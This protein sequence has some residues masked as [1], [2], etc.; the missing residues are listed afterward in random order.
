MLHIFP[1]YRPHLAYIKK[2]THTHKKP[3]T[4]NPSECGC[5]IYIFKVVQN[6]MQISYYISKF[7]TS[8]QLSQ[9]LLTSELYVFK[10]V[11]KLMPLRN[12]FSCVNFQ[13]AVSPK[14]PFRPSDTWPDPANCSTATV[15]I[16]QEFQVPITSQ[17]QAQSLH[18]CL[19]FLNETKG[20]PQLI[21]IF[22][23]IG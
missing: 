8:G 10:S 14:Y 12:V 15:H 13:A 11:Q 23:H 1:R 22:C 7:L 20:R 17:V 4:Y 2:R 5:Y 16:H 3:T 9:C 6:K 18:F 21:T 19:F